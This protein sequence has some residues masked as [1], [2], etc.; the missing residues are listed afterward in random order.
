MIELLNNTQI[1]TIAISSFAAIGIS[2]SGCS[3]NPEVTYG[4]GSTDPLTTLFSSVS[5]N[6]DKKDD[7]KQ[8]QTDS[9][10]QAQQM[11]EASVEEIPT[12]TAVGYAVVSTQPGHSDAQ[13]RLMAIRAARMA[14]M[15]DLAE[16]IHGL[17]VDSNTTVVD[18]MVQNDTFRGVVSGTIRGARTVRINPTGSDTY[19]IVLEIDREMMTY[20]LNVARQA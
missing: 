18:L 13:R 5:S 6:D 3:Y 16:Q 4:E 2:I 15:R 9:L 10:I 12:L 17:K 8:S 7:K 19:E 11:L 14:A 20:L 1:K